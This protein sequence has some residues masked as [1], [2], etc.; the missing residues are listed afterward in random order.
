MHRSLIILPLLAA[1][2]GGQVQTEVAAR[3]PV[4]FEGHCASLEEAPLTGEACVAWWGSTA[5]LG[6]QSSE[7]CEDMGGHWERGACPTEQAVGHCRV[8]LRGD[9]GADLGEQWTWYADSRANHAD[10][11]GQCAQLGGEWMSGITAS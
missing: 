3:A 1:C 9:I 4:G 2:A 5:S 10:L 6:S 8:A 7:L 11:Q